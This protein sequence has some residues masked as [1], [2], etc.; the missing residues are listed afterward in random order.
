M[1]PVVVDSFSLCG[2]GQLGV[3]VVGRSGRVMGTCH[4]KRVIG[5]LSLRGSTKRVVSIGLAR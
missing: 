1:T 4:R 2:S 3:R 5:R